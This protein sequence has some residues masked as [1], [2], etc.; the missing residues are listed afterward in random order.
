MR[1]L[2]Y[3]KTDTHLK[4]KVRGIVVPGREISPF[5]DGGIFIVTAT[6]R[7][8]RVNPGAKSL[9]LSKYCWFEVEVRGT[10]IA[11]YPQEGIAVKSFRLIERE[12][13]S[14]GDEDYVPSNCHRSSEKTEY[15]YPE[16]SA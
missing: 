1:T 9:Q 2:A 11:S 13:E 5:N 4:I 12:S 6:G 3:N 14:I 16:I 7:E 15:G 10:W 8:L